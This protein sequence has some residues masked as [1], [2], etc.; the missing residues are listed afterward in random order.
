MS[1]CPACVY[2]VPVGRSMPMAPA[3]MW[4]PTLLEEADLRAIL[5]A[6]HMSRALVRPTPVEVGECAQFEARA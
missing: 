6:P 4:R 2:Y 1:I 3:C 5:P